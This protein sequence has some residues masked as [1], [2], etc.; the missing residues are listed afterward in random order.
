MQ[1]RFSLAPHGFSGEIVSSILSD[2][3]WRS[4]VLGSAGFFSGADVSPSFSLPC[5]VFSA[6]LRVQRGEWPGVCWVCV[7]HTHVL[8]PWERAA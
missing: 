4:G 3:I 1:A 7:Q 5:L 8:L 6:G 2:S